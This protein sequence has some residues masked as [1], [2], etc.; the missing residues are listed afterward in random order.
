MGGVSAISCCIGSGQMWMMESIIATLLLRGSRL[1]RRRK[2]F[3]II[4]AGDGN[5]PLLNGG[6]PE[7]LS[8]F[9]CEWPSLPGGSENENRRTA[10]GKLMDVS[11]FSALFNKYLEEEKRKAE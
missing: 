1:R 7:R 2:K 4:A 9:A 11:Y 6:L 8:Y 5:P 10:D 3:R